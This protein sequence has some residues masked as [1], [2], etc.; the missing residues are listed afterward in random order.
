MKPFIPATV[1][2]YLLSPCNSSPTRSDDM[3][4]A[5]IVNYL[6]YF[7]ESGVIMRGHTA[8]KPKELSIAKSVHSCAFASRYGA[9]DEHSLVAYTTT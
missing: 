1:P 5:M 8:H 3:A 4:L 7:D 9:H 2:Q 6:F